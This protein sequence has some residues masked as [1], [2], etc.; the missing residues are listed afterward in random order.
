M[1]QISNLCIT[2]YIICSSLGVSS[3]QLR[4]QLL[5]GNM[6]FLLVGND[7]HSSRQSFVLK[8]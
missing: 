5:I 2:L 6:V 7:K 4:K 1:I 8:S 3:A